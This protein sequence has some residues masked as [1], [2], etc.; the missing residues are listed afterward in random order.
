MIAEYFV[1]DLIDIHLAFFENSVT[2]SQYFHINRQ[3][4]ANKCGTHC[5]IPRK[6][7]GRI[8]IPRVQ[9]EEKVAKT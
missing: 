9:L 4:V 1:N 3:V 2:K 8:A 5:V 6:I 7:P